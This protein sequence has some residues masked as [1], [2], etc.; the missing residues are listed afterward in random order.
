M[1][2]AT[3]TDRCGTVHMKT[4][5]ELFLEK[6]HYG[7]SECGQIKQMDDRSHSQEPKGLSRFLKNR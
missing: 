2:I 4:R 7:Q 5:S 6:E 1:C 3:F